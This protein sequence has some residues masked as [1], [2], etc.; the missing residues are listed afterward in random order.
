MHLSVVVLHVRNAISL[1]RTERNAKRTLIC[2]RM[3]P[4]R[5]NSFDTPSHRCGVFMAVCEHTVK[6]NSFMVLSGEAM[7]SVGIKL[8]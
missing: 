5:Y 7:T 8:E 3:N 2:C 1:Y 4:E 6:L